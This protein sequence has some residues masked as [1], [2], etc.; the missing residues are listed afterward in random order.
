[1]ISWPAT[2]PQRAYQDGYQ[3]GL[4][5]GR[6]RSDTDAGIPKVRLRFSYVPRPL[7]VTMEMTE[8]QRAIF[9]GFV[10]SDLKKGVLPFQFPAQEGTGTWVVQ[11]GQNMPSWTTKGVG[12]LVTLDL[13]RLP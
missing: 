9:E 4:G 1:M 8:A 12:W 7:S 5:D 13:V 3:S 6:I 2:L 11:I 10:E